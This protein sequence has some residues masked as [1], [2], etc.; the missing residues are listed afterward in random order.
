M[1][2][3]LAQAASGLYPPRSGKPMPGRPLTTPLSQGLRSLLSFSL[4]PA[5]LFT[6]LE[7]NVSM[8]SPPDQHGGTSCAGIQSSGCST[9]T[10]HP[11]ASPLHPVPTTGG[12]LTGTMAPTLCLP[13]RGCQ[14]GVVAGSQLS[15]TWTWSQ[16]PRRKTPGSV[17]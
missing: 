12:P 1:P 4:M 5:Q 15:L 6:P 9:P 13:P 11:L 7:R 14:A 10:A 16:G 2:F 8:C 3:T 17:T